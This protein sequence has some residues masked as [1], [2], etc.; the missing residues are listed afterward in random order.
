MVLT[1][2]AS[3]L[4]W[5][6][7]SAQ[8]TSSSSRVHSGRPLS[9]TSSAVHL[10]PTGHIGPF[11]RFPTPLTWSASAVQLDGTVAEDVLSV[12]L[13]GRPR[14][15]REFC[16]GVAPTLLSRRRSQ[17]RVD[18]S[19]TWFVVVENYTDAPQSLV[20]SVFETTVLSASRKLEEG[21]VSDA[22]RCL[23]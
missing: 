11:H 23:Q 13:F 8:V 4:F 6:K 10:F 20:L 15:S 9:K 19:V 14:Q 22:A 16:G 3:S 7:A 5:E 17:T 18:L 2:N 12:R 21:A 1:I